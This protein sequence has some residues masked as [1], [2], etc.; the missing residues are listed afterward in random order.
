M[1][2]RSVDA[3]LESLIREVI[4]DEAP[5]ETLTSV[6]MALC[7]VSVWQRPNRANLTASKRQAIL[8]DRLTCTIASVQSRQPTMP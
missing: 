2:V 6:L 1:P 5:G 8:V 4:V 7:W 3:G